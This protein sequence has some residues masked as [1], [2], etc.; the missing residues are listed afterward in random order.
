MSLIL[1]TTKIHGQDISKSGVRT[2]VG[3]NMVTIMPFEVIT[4]D[5]SE[6][7][8]MQKN[9]AKG[10]VPL[11][12]Y[13]PK[14]HNPL[15]AR[16]LERKQGSL[17]SMD[18]S[19]KRAVMKITA[20]DLAKANDE[21]MAQYAVDLG[22]MESLDVASGISRKSLE[23]VI[24]AYVG[25]R[26]KKEQEKAAAEPDEEYTVERLNMMAPSRILA[27]LKQHG[28]ARPEETVRSLGG[29]DEVRAMAVKHFLKG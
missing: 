23:E 18:L 6:Q 20:D 5:P 8:I 26:S 11:E 22:I 28:Q 10:N 25:I 21:T 17:G 7:R 15:I 13:E 2:C 19:R 4:L 14:K 12:V 1:L 9:A 29:D 16:F 3:T 27:L 24:R